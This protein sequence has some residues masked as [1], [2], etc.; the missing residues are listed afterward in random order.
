MKY[1]DLL[2]YLAMCITTRAVKVIVKSVRN[3]EGVFSISAAFKRPA[4]IAL[5]SG[6][7]DRK[8]HPPTEKSR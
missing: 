3:E 7:H 2:A 5:R 8:F 4:T 1:K 6:S